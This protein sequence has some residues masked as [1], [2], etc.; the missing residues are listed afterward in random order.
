[1]DP[2]AIRTTVRLFAEIV[3]VAAVIPAISILWSLLHGD[4][5]KK[6]AELISRP[7]IC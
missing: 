1:L 7:K 4:T 5:T 2:L 6:I 3:A